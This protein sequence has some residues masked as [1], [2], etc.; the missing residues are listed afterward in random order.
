MDTAMVAATNV[1]SLPDISRIEPFNGTHYK[2]WQEKVM[3]TLDV[4]GYAFAITDPKPD[5][6][7]ELQNW[8][9]ANKI[10]RHIILSTL[11]NALFDVYCPYKTATEIWESLNKKHFHKP[12]F[13]PNQNP[14]LKRNPN[15]TFKKKGNYFVCGK[16]GHYSTQCRFL[17]TGEAPSKPQ[18]SLIES[19]IIAV[20]ISEVNMVAHNKNWVIDSGPTRHICADI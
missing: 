3:S 9:K 6:E 13:K 15:S 17:K 11:S 1:K 20:V 7:K 14:K 19:D 5:K 8:E 2:R 10:C 18:A 12:N 4:T 16:P